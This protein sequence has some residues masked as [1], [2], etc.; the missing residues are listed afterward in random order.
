MKTKAELLE[1]DAV[2]SAVGTA[3]APPAIRRPISESIYVLG[4]GLPQARRRLRQLE[5]NG[6]VGIDY[7][8]A[9]SRIACDEGIR[10][11]EMRSSTVHHRLP[12]VAGD[13]KAA[14]TKAL[15]Y[16]TKE[17]ACGKSRV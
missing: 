2:A 9:M 13:G 17:T 14:L 15:A 12:K 11:R 8:H 3:Q 5:K 4:A 16:V 10:Q 6:G 7:T 1:E